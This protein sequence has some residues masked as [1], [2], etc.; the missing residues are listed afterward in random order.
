MK[1]SFF[2]CCFLLG[3]LVKMPA[4]TKFE[5]EYRLKS[6]E[7]PV[8]AQT[9]VHSLGAKKKIKWYKEISQEGKSIEAK[10][11]IRDHCHSIEFDQSGNL[12]D[13]EVKIDWEEVAKTTRQQIENYLEETFEKHK[14]RKIQRQYS[15][16]SEAIRG[17]LVEEKVTKEVMIRYEIVVKGKKNGEMNLYELL[18]SSEGQLLESYTIELRN[19]DNLEY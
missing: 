4:Q 16:D 11:K 12:E 17:A 6:S 10:T 8:V 19:T 14:I 15:G 13:V 5:R 7:I 9:Y 1:I 18:F 2:L 3:V